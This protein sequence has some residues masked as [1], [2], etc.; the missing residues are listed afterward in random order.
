MSGG[1]RSR[2]D[3]TC[4]VGAP[5]RL[6]ILKGQK[7]PSSRAFFQ[8]LPRFSELD[9]LVYGT[10]LLELNNRSTY[11][12][13]QNL[14]NSLIRVT[15]RQPLGMLIDSSFHDFELMIPVM[16]EL[17]PSLI[18]NDSPGDAFFTFPTK[19]IAVTRHETLQSEAICSAST[20]LAYHDDHPSLYLIPNLDM[21]TKTKDIHWVCPGNPFVRDVTNYL[22]GLRAKSPEQKCQAKMSV[23]DEQ[24]GTKVE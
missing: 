20:S 3:Y 14:T 5:I 7:I 1:Q 11:L 23:K 19:M 18:T 24:T 9:L 22:C 2:F 8:P 17:P 10:P 15:A 21:C 4:T 16:G 12:L 13:V 6:V